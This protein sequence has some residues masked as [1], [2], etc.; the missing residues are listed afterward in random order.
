MNHLDYA[1]SKRSFISLLFLSLLIALS[2][3]LAHPTSARAA[4]A[5]PIPP[6]T[7]SFKQSPLPNVIVIGTGGTLAGKAADQTSFQ[8]YRAGT[9]P[10]ADLVSQLPNKDKIAD[11]ATYQF[12]NKG[13]GSY[14]MSDLY[15]LSL[16]VDAALEQYDGAVVTSGTDTM[17]EIAYF[18]NLTVRSEKP[19][20]VTGA[21]RPWDVIGTDAPANLYNAIKLAGSGKTKSFGT[22][23]MLNDVI[24]AAREVTKS[25]SHRMDT[26]QT[27]MVGALGY[28]DETNI[29]IYR[30]PAKRLKAGKPDWA[31]PFNLK[32]ITKDKLPAVEIV[33]A[34]QD[35]AGGAITGFANEGV[36]GIVTAGT[37]A[38]GISSKMSTA[39]SNAI[40]QGVIF[41]TTTRTGSGTMYGSSNGI[42]AGDSL[43][44]QHARIMLLLSLAFSNDYNTIKQWF[45]TVGTQEIKL[46]SQVPDNKAPEWPAGGSLEALNVGQTALTLTWPS[47][48]DNI[49][50]TQ[51]RI[52]DTGS[53]TVVGSVY[54][55]VTNGVYSTVSGSTYS[56]VT[57]S[58]YYYNL[59]GLTAGTTYTF[60]VKAEDA[61]GNQ[62]VGLSKTVQT[63]PASRP[64]RPGSS[65]GGAASTSSKSE[66][67]IAPSGTG[68]VSLN[69]AIWIT[70]PA[71][72]SGQELRV[73]VEEL[74]NQSNLIS[75]GSKLISPIFEILKNFSENFDKPVTISF[76][77]DPAKVE[78]NQH[79]SVF[80]YDEE[81]KTWIEIGGTVQDNQIKVDVDHFTKFAVFAVENKAAETTEGKPSFSDTTGHWAEAAIKWASSQNI[82][83]GY[84]DGSF[85]PDHSVTRAEFTL[86]LMNVLKPQ[87]EGRALELTDKDTIG[88]WAQ[89]AV[90]Q[91]VEAGIIK[92]YEDGTFRPN[93]QIN[94]AEL[95]SMIAAALKLAPQADA[96]T[97][98]TD[99][100]M[101]PKWAKGSIEAIRKLGVIEGRDG[102]RFEPTETATRAEAVTILLKMTQTKK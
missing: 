36:K 38:G 32:T 22:V 9:Y 89:K 27:P 41:V 16:A 39:R 51:Y 64:S 24:H 68:T 97:G 80:Y 34:Y 90:A 30:V 25:N 61:A 23:L 87:G 52:Y 55:T 21:M 71:G 99:D 4:E 84:P 70:I 67:T 93:T 62:S 85:K 98:F 47:A 78:A 79:P 53:N 44:A 15:D 29:R 8:N 96:T 65:G 100:S 5:I 11:V 33:Y 1:T 19:V 37:G 56:S 14:S 48:V 92:G 49:G 35:A 76:L 45:E 83:S 10:I 102:N 43:N 57:G 69:N 72:A 91:S 2:T 94:R 95:V 12:G 6:L 17:E 75:E 26:F 20:V 42:I 50:V 18:L 7:D 86:M 28:I 13:S 73:T 58:V 88:A 81:K 63:L 3:M 60:T 82:V 66:L 59:S 40:K 31:T 74:T 54:P 46:A 101:I 77:F